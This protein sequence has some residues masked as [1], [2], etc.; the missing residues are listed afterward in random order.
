MSDEPTN[1]RQVALVTGASR[2]IGR[3]IALELAR[4]GL[5]VIGT[6]TT[7]SG[8]QAISNALSGHDGCR[9]ICLDVTDAD[10]VEAALDAL[11]KAH[12]AL[13]VLVNNAGITRDTLAMRMKDSDWDAVIDTNLKAVFRM[14]RAAIRPMIKQ[15]YGRIVNITSVVGASGNAGQANYAAAK[16]GVAGL[17]RSLA[18]E[19]GSRG[20][21][22]NCVAPGFIATDMTDALA[23]AQKQALL[24]QIPL[25]RLG[26]VDDVAQAVAFLVS[27]G[28]GYVT[29]TELHVNGGMYMS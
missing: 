17:T 2:G 18:R 14:S 4:R 1:S 20:I 12:G 22:V 26:S 6:A 11:L 27:A 10:G 19:L 13:H 9:G 23:D 29:G 25:G 3:A 5:I 21:T 24:A 28:A 15:R 8:A 16:A 7:E